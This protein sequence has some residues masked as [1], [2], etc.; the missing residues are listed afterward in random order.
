MDVRLAESSGE[1][2]G[3][4]G[5]HDAD[6]RDHLQQPGCHLPADLGTEAVVRATLLERR[7]S[8]SQ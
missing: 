7:H 2:G 1:R 3:D 8:R 5:A 4:T 6:A